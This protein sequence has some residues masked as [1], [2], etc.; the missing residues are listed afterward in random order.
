MIQFFVPLITHSSPSRTARVRIAAGSE[1]ASG[2]DRQNAG[3]H[4]PDAQRGRNRSFSSGDPKRWIGSVPSSWIIRISAHAADACASSSTATCSISVPVPGAAVL[5]VERQRE[6]VLLGEQAADV[7]RVLVGRV[8]LR[9]ARRDPLPR[10][11][12]DHGAEVLMLLGKLVD[13]RAHR[14]GS[15]SATSSAIRR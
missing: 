7:P 1:P 11:L 2:S 6:H 15:V 4:S 5:L 10:E 8:D 12:P 3:D 13:R 9:R 14:L